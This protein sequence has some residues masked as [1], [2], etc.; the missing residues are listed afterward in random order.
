[1]IVNSGNFF[2]G[3]C[4]ES[5]SQEREWTNGGTLVKDT[6]PRHRLMKRQRFIHEI[7]EYFSYPV[8]PPVGSSI[9]AAEQHQKS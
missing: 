1:M 9:I 5:C 8:S 4:W 7:L 6:G 2:K 3:K